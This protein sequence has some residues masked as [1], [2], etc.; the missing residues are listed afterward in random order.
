[1]SLTLAEGA[2][3]SNDQLRAG[4][5]ETVVKHSPIL[6]ALPFQEVVGNALAYNRELAMATA[7]FYAV[8]GTWGES[9]PTFT[10]VTET[11]KI[12]GG[13]AD[14]DQY[15]A[16]TRS[17]V[18][19]LTA[20]T[21]ELKSK[22]VAYAFEQAFI[23]GDPATDANAF[24]GIQNLVPA[25]MEIPTVGALALADL[26]EA[27]DLIRGGDPSLI[28][29]TRKVRRAI[30]ALGRASGTSGVH[31]ADMGQLGRQAVAYNGIPIA[32][33]DF[34]TDTE[35]SGANSSSIYVLRF[36]DDGIA[37]LQGAGGMQVEDVGPLETKD[38]RRYRIK[39]YVSIA[40]FNELAAARLSGITS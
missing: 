40:L 14:V 27:L 32:V 17:N 3:L 29:T 15:L 34:M 2:K 11:L 4:V 16:R 35:G 28:V 8:G 21:I 36:G 1:M 39:W 13:D 31:T 20:V 24:T 19:D 25:S 12:L 22:A 7:A 33:N 5:I 18:Q 9:T 26:D 6:A 38:A 37:G 30:T 10:R 23:T